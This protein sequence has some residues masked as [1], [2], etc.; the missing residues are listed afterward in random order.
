MKPTDST[1]TWQRRIAD[2]RTRRERY[3]PLWE[4]F[5]RMHTN[6]Y[7]AAPGKNDDK[8]VTF[9][10]GDQVKTSLI[11]RN[12]EQTLAL[13]EVPEIGVRASATDYA[14]GLGAEDTHRESVVE[15]ALYGSLLQ[16]GLIKDF[17][18]VD[19]IKRDAIICGHGVNYS[20][21]RMVEQELETGRVP[22]YT[23]TGGALAPLLEAGAPVL[24]PIKEKR[25]TWQRVQD[26]HVSPLEFLCDASAKR[27]EKAPWHGF[28]R[29]IQLAA[30]KQDPR[31]R[32]PDDVVGTDF[33]IRDL[34]GVEGQPEETLTDAVMVIVIWEVI[35]KEL[36]TFLET[37]P[38]GAGGASARAT[39]RSVTRR[40][41]ERQL[42][43]IGVEPWPVTFSHP[44][45]SPFTFLVLIPAND[46]PFGISQVEHARNQALEADKLRTRQAN[47]AR[48]IKRIPW[49]RKGRLDPD[50]LRQA[51]RSDDME[52]VG[53]D[54][55]EGEK[56]EQLFGELPVPSVHPDIYKQYIIAEQ[57]IDKTTGVS[58]VAGGGADTATEA[59]HI[60]D[61]G[62]ARPR[63]KKRLYLKFLSAVAA[64]HRDLLR[65]F[66]PEG[67]TL[68]APDVDGR[69]LTLAYGR[70]AFAGEMEIEVIAGG[71]A[72]AIS[73][74]KQKLMIEASGLLMG[75]YGPMF[76]RVFL[77]QLL[78]MFDFRDI[79]EL[80]RAAM[81]GMGLPAGP[82]L[83][84][85]APPPGYSPDN[86][87][88]AQ[89]V[90]GG[91]NAANEGRIRG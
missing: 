74:V 39:G 36:I 67:E 19:Y 51:L 64:R 21:W 24:E 61:I 29:P 66:A 72:M 87:S 43:P 54:V 33:V 20:W 82:A 11:H 68:V 81:M 76:D 2:A 79:N 25:V 40:A 23:E 18:E 78:T 57:G 9:P 90:R 38:P 84:G 16:S 65:E 12:I 70:A 27:L 35:R 10:N 45:H 28:D 44:D 22:V 52:P 86:Y 56:P 75:K 63:R 50:Q 13:I 53:L 73:P 83:P 37:A 42:I 17:E 91:I 59:E 3:L 55:L 80:M 6:G 5:G 49:Y 60:F 88:N 15:Q 46:H 77:R 8:L 7:R 47:M 48:Q 32:I 41:P 85:Q 4:L 34:Y 69:P 89:T 31:Y 62:N 26:E 58:D 71:G 30:L 14:R 1:A